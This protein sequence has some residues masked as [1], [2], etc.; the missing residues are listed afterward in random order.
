MSRK[1]DPD[2]NPLRGE[3][4]FKALLKKVGLGE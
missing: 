2:L 4:R 3:P 1:V